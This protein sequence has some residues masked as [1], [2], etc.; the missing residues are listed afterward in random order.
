L[1]VSPII[2]RSLARSAEK[3]KTQTQQNR[4][5]MSQRL[6]TLENCPDDTV[7]TGFDIDY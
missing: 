7:R 3:E 2:D 5:A 4:I 1:I 6:F